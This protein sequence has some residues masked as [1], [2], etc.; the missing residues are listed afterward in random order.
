MDP[1]NLSSQIKCG[2]ISQPEACK[3][4]VPSSLT[5]CVH[6]SMNLRS[7]IFLAYYLPDFF[8]FFVEQMV[9]FSAKLKKNTIY[10][11][12]SRYCA[13]LDVIYYVNTEAS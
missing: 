5:V 1:W 4:D 13:L 10:Y 3:T 6:H 2:D 9:I 12:G 11:K 7:F 8:F